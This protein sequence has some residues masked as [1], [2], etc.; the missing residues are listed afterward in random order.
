MLRSI[1]KRAFRGI[2]LDLRSYT[3]DRS[4]SARLFKLLSLHGVDLVFDVGANV[5]Q[6]ALS[7]REIG[8]KGRIVSFEPLSMAWGQLQSASKSDPLWEVAPRCAIGAEDGEIEMHVARNSVSSS[9]LG[10]L[11]SVIKAAPSAAYVGTETAPLR[12]LDQVGEE[13]NAENSRLFMKID[14]QGYEDKVLRG[15]R[16]LLQKTVGLHVEVSL[17]ALYEGQPLF[18]CIIRLLAEHGFEL[19]GFDPGF[20]DP[21]T[22]RLLQADAI[23]FRR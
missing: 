16:H 21:H 14:T 23:F 8:Y 4:E 15:A 17:V 1:V 12:R 18:G 13:F 11:D 2:G 3:P 20:F 5:G 6:F 19:W 10:M 22:G 9:A 7:L